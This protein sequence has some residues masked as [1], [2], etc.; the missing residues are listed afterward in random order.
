VPGLRARLR[1]NLLHEALGIIR[2]AIPSAELLNIR[3]SGAASSSAAS[4]LA[5]STG[6][7]ARLLTWAPSVVLQTECRCKAWAARAR[8]SR[9]SSHPP[10]AAFRRKPHTCAYRCAPGSYLR[11]RLLWRRPLGRSLT[12]S[13]ERC[14]ALVRSVQVVERE[15]LAQ[16]ALEGLAARCSRDDIDEQ[17]PLRQLERASRS[18]QWANTSA[19]SRS[20]SA[21]TTSA[22]GDSPHLTEGT[23]NT[24][25][26]AIPV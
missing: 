7:D 22:T 8:S 12:Y 11:W 10:C 6:L 15:L 1:P 20:G 9:Q 17:N 18:L 21:R 13:C 19:S 24:A 5:V 14:S 2:S 3:S 16:L 23:P 25:A 26:S 4:M